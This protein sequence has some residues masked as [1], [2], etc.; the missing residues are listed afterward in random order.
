M[1]NCNEFFVKPYYITWFKF[2]KVV[3]EFEV[4]VHGNCN[5]KPKLLPYVCQVQVSIYNVQ[6]G[7]NKS[8]EWITLSL[9]SDNEIKV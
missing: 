5:N 4:K 7:L 8:A 6:S 1:A 2:S 9:L 3:E